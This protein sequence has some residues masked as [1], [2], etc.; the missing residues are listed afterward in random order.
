MLWLRKLKWNSHQQ[1]IWALDI[2]AMN[3]QGNQT[4]LKN[5]KQNFSFKLLCISWT[6]K[7]F[8]EMN[9]LAKVVDY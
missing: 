6:K 1:T 2:I 5:V 7:A 9:L 3:Q 4:P 8:F